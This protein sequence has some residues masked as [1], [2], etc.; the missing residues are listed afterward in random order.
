MVSDVYKTGNACD[1]CAHNNPLYQ[2]KHPLQVFLPS[3]PLEFVAMDILGPLPRATNR[4][5]R[6]MV[7]TDRYSK[8]TRAIPTWRTTATHAANVF[9]DHCVISHDIS[10]FLLIDNGPQ[11]VRKFFATICTYL[12]VKHLTTMAYHPKTNGQVEQYNKT[13]V[14]CLCHYIVENQRDWDMFIQPLTHACSTQV[15]RSTNTTPFSV[16][17]SRHPPGPAMLPEKRVLH[18]HVSQET[19]IQATRLA[20]QERINELRARADKHARA[21]EQQYR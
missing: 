13:I 10:T 9:F 5:Q 7:I 14:T 1:S 15:H 21:S 20:L 8:L 17:I 6:V 11:F 12:G 2:R 4:N 18:T 19:T 16:V 3:G